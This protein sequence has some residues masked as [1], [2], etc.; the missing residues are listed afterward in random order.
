[1][2][3]KRIELNSCN[4]IKTI[5][6]LFVVL[7]H[8]TRL[9]ATSGWFNQAPAQDSVVLQYIT[10]WI[11]YFHIYAFVL[12][13]GYIFAYQKFEQGKYGNFGAFVKR[14]S[15]RLLVPYIFVSV[16][17]A[18]PWHKFYYGSSATEMIKS[19]I[20]GEAPA[21]LWF[22]LM[23]FW[24]FVIAFFFPKSIVE[25][26]ILGGGYFSGHL[27]HRNC[28]KYGSSQFME[29]IHGIAVSPF[30]LD[31][32]ATPLLRYRKTA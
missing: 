26:P 17:W 3:N 31:W 10:E 1:M 14:K 8:A 24:I 23:L 12:V 5:L 30:F 9:W 7:G 15:M 2:I 18:A 21:Q 4:F 25:R 29:S 20:L 13:S 22:L 11:G 16:I 6:M 27:L 19:F 32:Y 28:R